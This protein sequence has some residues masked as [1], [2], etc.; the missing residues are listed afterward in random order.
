M[1]LAANPSE[2]RYLN[3]HFVDADEAAAFLS[4]TRRRIL[5]LA[6]A[7]HLPGHRIGSGARCVWRFRLSELEAALV[8]QNRLSFASRKNK[9]MVQPRAVPDAIE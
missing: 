5:D 3:E 1:T 4:I 2:E 9:G 7:G 8:E 6:R